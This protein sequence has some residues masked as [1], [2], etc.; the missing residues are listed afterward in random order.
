M[1]K[2]RFLQ[3]HQQYCRDTV[4]L[5]FMSFVHP[6]YVELSK[7]GP[8]ALPW[9]LERLKDTIGHDLGES[10]DGT[11][12]PWLSA[13]LIGQYSVGVCWD[14][15]PEKYSGMLDKVRDFLL[16]WGEARGHIKL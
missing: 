15:F 2:E 13:D 6:A 12:S 7:A 11:N 3:L 16:Q 14:G 5:S 1:I 9:A 4:C 8:E 10:F